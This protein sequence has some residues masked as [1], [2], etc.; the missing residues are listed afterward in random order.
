MKL[1]RSLFLF[2]LS[3]ATIL[4][5][6][7]PLENPDIVDPDNPEGPST[8]VDPDNPEDPS[9]PVDPTPEPEPEPEVPVVFDES[10]YDADLLGT[11]Y[12]RLGT[13]KVEPNSLTLTG[14]EVLT[15][16]PTSI[17]EITENNAIRSAVNYEDE[18]TGETYRIHFNYQDKMELSLERYEDGKFTVLDDFMPSIHEFT[19]AYTA[20]GDGSCNNNMFII[21]NDYSP[22]YDTFAINSYY[23]LYGIYN[24]TYY[25]AKSYFDV[26]DGTRRLMI[27]IYDYED[28]YLYYS[29]YLEVKDNVS[30][31]YDILLEYEVYISDIGMIYGS[32]FDSENATLTFGYELDDF[33]T[34]LSNKITLNDEEFDI[35]IAFDNGSIYKLTNES[36]EIILR[37]YLNGI[38]LIENGETKYY[39]IN[40]T[41]HLSGTF[42]DQDLEFSY[43]DLLDELLINGNSTE[44]QKKVVNGELGISVLIDNK[45]YFFTEFKDDIAIK[46]SVDGSSRYLLAYDTFLANFKNNY[47]FVGNGESEKLS[48]GDDFKVTY[49][50]EK[51]DA[52]L[53]YDPLEEFPSVE[54]IVKGKT[55]VFSI[56]ELNN[57]IFTL[58]SEGTSKN[59]FTESILTGLRQEYTSGKGEIHV[60]D[61]E[62][63]Y[64]GE[65]LKFDLK[66]YY[67]AYSFT[68]NVAL[69]FETAEGEEHYIIYYKYEMLTDYKVGS[70][71]PIETYVTKE[72]F[73]SFVGRYVFNGTY[74]PESFEL[75]S[76]GKFYADVLNEKGDG[77]ILRQEKEYH[78]G[79]S[80][81][82]TGETQVTLQFN[83]KG[84]WL[85][86]YKNGYS[87][88]VFETKYVDERLFTVNGTF[89]SENNA[90]VVF[91]N[92]D[93]V[94]IDGEEATINSLS[95][96]VVANGTITL[97]VT[98][99]DTTQDLV[100]KL[101]E[102][103]EVESATLGETLLNDA[104][105][106]LNVFKGKYKDTSG[107]TYNVSDYVGIGGAI[108][109]LKV[110]VTSSGGSSSTY[111]EYAVVNRNGK[112]ALLIEGIGY[113]YYL[114]YDGSSVTAESE[115]TI[116]LPPPPPPP[117]PPSI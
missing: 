16:K 4:T 112:L 32:Y 90:N 100:F 42:K 83:H 117:P 11:F 81:L 111:T 38:S 66:S 2:V 21:S 13:L 25:Y 105:L 1:R 65:T 50:G 109:G 20:Y 77:L 101:D 94:Y 19:G 89:A 71:E 23:P 95:G 31:L 64:L 41:S 67:N 78:I 17:E 98:L 49:L 36:R 35:A 110:T 24:K 107:N 15:L 116:P 99:N 58:T 46:V 43:D 62:I 97:N 76:D 10:D 70:E 68:N 80:V 29:T 86:L 39:P 30:Y 92:R 8:P 88:L 27:D 48:I 57:G 9:T 44:Y 75:T 79:V 72:A 102:N 87:L 60:S 114:I 82:A 69:Y 45:E 33:D 93:I 7:T 54:F 55:Y 63:N 52:T 26:I 34:L 12:S 74:G 104:N 3:G 22:I 91:I 14:E 6:C 37:P 73:D 113:N 5:S 47:E 85:Y 51:V 108:D 40:D 103:A 53:I 96:E 18:K 28:D 115:S 59:F 56:L 61:N 106:D 84:T